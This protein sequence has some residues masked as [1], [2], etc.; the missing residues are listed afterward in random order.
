MNLER[1]QMKVK[2]IG[3]RAEPDAFNWAVSEGTQEVPILIAVERVAAPSGY[4]EP[5]MLSHFRNRL[6]H[7]IQTH[8]P[9]RAGLRTPESIARAGGESARR[10]LRLEGVLLAASSES[11][12]SVT[13]G[14]LVTVNRLLGSKSAKLFLN[15]TEYRGIDWSKHPQAKREAILMSAS[16]LP[17]ETDASHS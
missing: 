3:M 10:R 17:S 8:N 12:L 4:L 15:S 9:E 13:L 7:I 11:G 1:M 6:L 14:A 2:V 5:E 16:L